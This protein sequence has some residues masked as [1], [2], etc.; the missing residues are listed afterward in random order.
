MHA[1]LF[2]PEDTLHPAEKKGARGHL[3]PCIPLFPL[4]QLCQYSSVLPLALL[5][6]VLITASFV[7]VSPAN[8]IPV[9]PD[10]FK[11]AQVGSHSQ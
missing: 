9:R 2:F 4:R 6:L 1:P 11:G 3:G 7:G 8:S 10:E 5:T